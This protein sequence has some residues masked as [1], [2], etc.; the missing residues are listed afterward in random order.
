MNS[1]TGKIGSQ[2]NERIDRIILTR[3]KWVTV[4]KDT[5][6]S[7]DG[8]ELSYITVDRSDSVIII[9]LQDGKFV[10]TE[11]QFRPGINK[12][13]LDFVGGRVNLPKPI[14]SAEVTL[15]RELSLD[16]SVKLDLLPVMKMPLYGDSA[17]SSQKLYGYVV[18]L[19]SKVRLPE[20]AHYYTLVELLEKLKCLQCRNILLE[21]MNHDLVPH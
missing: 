13:T 14:E 12:K 20:I 5:C 9:V 16:K 7:N 10:L 18:N 19:E 2:P 21:A 17:F 15:R 11:E 6:L 8:H 3:S 4:Y 1:D